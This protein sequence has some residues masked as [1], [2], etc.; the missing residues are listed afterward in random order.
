MQQSSTKRLRH[1][2]ITGEAGFIGSQI[3][4]RLVKVKT[5]VTPQWYDTSGQLPA[6]VAALRRQPGAM[7]CK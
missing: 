5:R 7:T 1:V 3:S 4:A 2:I 6:L